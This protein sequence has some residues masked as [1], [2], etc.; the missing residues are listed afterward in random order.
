MSNDLEKL[1]E[2]VDRSIGD[3]QKPLK[4]PLWCAVNGPGEAREADLGIAREKEGLIL[5]GQV[6]AKVG[7]ELTRFIEE[8]KNWGEVMK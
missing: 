4:L 7:K 5:K 6:I 8:I 3:L 1:V 2:E